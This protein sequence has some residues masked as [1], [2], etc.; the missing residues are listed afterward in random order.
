LKNDG[1][2]KTIGPLNRWGA[3]RYQ[4]LTFADPFFR[5]PR[6]LLILRHAK[7][8]WDSKAASDF[9]RPL[10]RRG[11]QDAPKIGAWHYREGLIPD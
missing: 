1:Y 11:K 8:D 3:T 5:M 4:A 7:S 2:V 9:D 10:A 6:E